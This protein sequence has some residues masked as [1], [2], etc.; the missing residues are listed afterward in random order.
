MVVYMEEVVITAKIMRV[1]HG[2]HVWLILSTH[3]IITQ[4]LK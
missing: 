4:M 2:C 3:N 1:R